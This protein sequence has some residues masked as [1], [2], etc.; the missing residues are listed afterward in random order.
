[1]TNAALAITTTSLPSASNGTAYSRALQASGGTPA[2]TWSIT[3]GS[4]PAGLT[5]AAT[6]GV[7]SGTPS[8]NGT[9]NFTATVTDNGSPAQ[10][11]SV[12]ISI[13]V[14]SATEV[15]GPGTTWYIRSDG[16]TRYSAN[17]PDGQCDGQGDTA[18]GGTG[19]NQHCAFNDFR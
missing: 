7:I 19:T 11:K 16:G 13:N 18:Y 17:R 4:L 10:S 9:S 8:T 6:T 15:T 3:A 14:F 2:Y 12:A 5:L 1:M